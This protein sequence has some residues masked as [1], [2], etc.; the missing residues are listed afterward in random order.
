M[1]PLSPGP[2]CAC[3]ACASET[4]A[5]AA[6][7]AIGPYEGRLRDVIHALKY[8]RRASLARPL[9][10]LLR[11]AGR[12]VIDGA[13][14][15]VPVP[16]HWTRRH[17]R[18]FNQAA[19]LAGQSGLPVIRALRRTRRTRPQVDLPAAARHRNV[20]GAFALAWRCR[21]T[22]SG[23]G[24]RFAAPPLAGLVLVLVD[25]VST[26]GATLEACARVLIAAGA[27]EVRALT[28]ARAVSRS[29]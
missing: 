11:D 9:G 13:D 15:A 20:A 5:V 25:D 16:L 28:A 26:T 6:A 12:G 10:A 7:R 18:G 24:R 23:L 19:L 14:A 29:R 3:A 22:R 27:R 21:L 17:Q 4:K 2:A 8:D 1:P